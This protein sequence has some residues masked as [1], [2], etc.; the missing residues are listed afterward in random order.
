MQDHLSNSNPPT[1]AETIAQLKE[2]LARLNKQL[3]S[4][5]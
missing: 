5:Q 4:R 3:E 2:E 1:E